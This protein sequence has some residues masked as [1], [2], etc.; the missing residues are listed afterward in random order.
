M[1]VGRE[2]GLASQYLSSSVTP[3]PPSLPQPSFPG[4]WKDIFDL[5]SFLQDWWE[6]ATVTGGVCHQEEK[7]T[8]GNLLHHKYPVAK[9]DVGRG[10]ALWQAQLGASR[11]FLGT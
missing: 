11:G 7:V 1:L 5:G 8:A 9:R 2:D 10:T 4:S 6:D 3:T